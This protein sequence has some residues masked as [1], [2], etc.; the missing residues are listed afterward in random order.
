MDDQ[1]RNVM[2]TITGFFFAQAYLSSLKFRLLDNTCKLAAK[3][4]VDDM[5]DTDFD[6]CLQSLFISTEGTFRRLRTFVSALSGLAPDL[7]LEIIAEELEKLG[8]A[9]PKVT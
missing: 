6:K 3:L 4:K 5:Q 7:A 1:Q 9:K 8:V 2:T